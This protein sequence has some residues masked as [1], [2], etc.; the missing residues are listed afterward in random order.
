MQ[1]ENPFSCRRVALHLGNSDE[2]YNILMYLRRS[3]SLGL[4]SCVQSRPFTLLTKG[5]Y[6][7]TSI[8]TVS[9]DL[10]QPRI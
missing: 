9:G 5:L 6:Q 10:L 3:V 1:K 2:S 7:A 4:L 8:D